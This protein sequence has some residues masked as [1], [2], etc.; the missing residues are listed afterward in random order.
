MDAKTKVED[1][2]R[3]TG[4]IGNGKTEIIITFS[5]GRKTSINEL[6]QGYHES[7]ISDNAKEELGKAID[8]LENCTFGL[9]NM[10]LL[11]DSIH[12][13]GLRGSLPDIVEQ[14]KKGFV[15]VTGENPWE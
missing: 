10:P 3:S 7:Q 4:I 2:L 9:V 11:P 6:I 15:K 12:V 5:D 1:Y 8:S 13:A 14:L